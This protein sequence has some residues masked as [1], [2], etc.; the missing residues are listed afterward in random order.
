MEPH[1]PSQDTYDFIADWIAP[2]FPYSKKDV[3][4][5]MG[6]VGV[7]A[8][9]VCSCMPGGILEIGTGESSIYLTLVAKKYDRPIIYCDIE[10]GKLIN[11]MSIKGYLDDDV[12]FIDDKVTITEMVPQKRAFATRCAS[13][14][15]FKK[16]KIP[17]L[18]LAFIDGDHNYEQVRKDFYNVVPYIVDD[19]YILLHDVYPIDENWLPDNVCG[20][21][22]K[23]RQEIEKD[24]A[25]QCLTLTKGTA[26]GVGLEIV[27]KKPKDLP[28]YK[29]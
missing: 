17:P 8:D 16:L 10:Y 6:F 11:P 21:V 7:F 27:R 20:T 28:Y 4:H 15:L 25:F 2:N 19:G 13:D 22:Y 14:D 12:E 1:K 9:Y 26:M 23:L 3:W 18:A 24:P 5:R 29:A